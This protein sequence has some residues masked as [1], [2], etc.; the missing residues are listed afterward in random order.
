MTLTVRG[1]GEADPVASNTRKDGSDDPRA[2]AKN[3]RV[4][5][6]FPKRP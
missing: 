5:I 3:R 4:E 1:R 6:T 2:R